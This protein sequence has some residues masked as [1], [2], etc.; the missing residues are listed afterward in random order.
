MILLG[1]PATRKDH[2]MAENEKEPS[3]PKK[4]RFALGEAIRTWAVPAAAIA[5]IL[6][7]IGHGISHI[8]KSEVRPIKQTVTSFESRFEKV[9]EQLARADAKADARFEK[10]D[11]QLARVDAKVDD[12]FEKLDDRLTKAEAKADRRF[13]KLVESVNQMNRKMDAHLT[14]HNI[15]N[16]AQPNASLSDPGGEAPVKPLAESAGAEGSSSG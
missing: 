13:E 1:K 9:D 15:K 5:T 6:V 2:T 12:R 16:D 3:D 10:V 8:V 7:G 4:E 14:L 11:E